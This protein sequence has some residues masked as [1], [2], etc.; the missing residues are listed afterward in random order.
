M[1]SITKSKK[2]EIFLC[3]KV[4]A[5]S[6]VFCYFFSSVQKTQ[7][8]SNLDLFFALFF[9]KIGANNPKKFF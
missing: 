4:T 7:A 9:S 6:Y 1:Q 2:Y 5:I 8:L 3:I